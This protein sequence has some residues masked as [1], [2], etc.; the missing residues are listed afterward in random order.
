MSAGFYWHTATPTCSL[1]MSSYFH[2]GSCVCAVVFRAQ[3][4]AHILALFTRSLLY[5]KVDWPVN[6]GSPGGFQREGLA[7]M[8]FSKD[9]SLPCH[10]K[11][12]GIRVQWGHRMNVWLGIGKRDSGNRETGWIWWAPELTQRMTSVWVGKTTEPGLLEK[13]LLSWY[14]SCWHGNRHPEPLSVFWLLVSTPKVWLPSTQGL[15]SFWT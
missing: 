13:I 12:I 3:S 15:Y 14:V 9:H 6:S 4:Q 7:S 1:T 10:E 5:K 11:W 8:A 2:Y